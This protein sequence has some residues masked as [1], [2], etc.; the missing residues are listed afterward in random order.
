MNGKNEFEITDYDGNVLWKS[1]EEEIDVENSRIIGFN[2]SITVVAEFK[3]ELKPF[4]FVW[5]TSSFVK[6]EEKLSLK[7]IDIACRNPKY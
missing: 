2:P 7:R 4:F 1:D 3:F 5:L 6:D